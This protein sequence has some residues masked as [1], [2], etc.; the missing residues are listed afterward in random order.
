MNEAQQFGGITYEDSPDFRDI[1]DEDGN[2]LPREQGEF[3]TENG[4]TYVEDVET[5]RREIIP[6]Y[7][8]PQEVGPRVPQE[9]IDVVH[10]HALTAYALRQKG[11]HEQR[12][13]SK[14][15]TPMAREI[16]MLAVRGIDVSGAFQDYDGKRGIIE[17]D[18]RERKID[19]VMDTQGL[20]YY[21]AERKVD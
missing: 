8:V 3:T 2:V 4:M 17:D 11:A 13:K 1:V 7:G 12:L 15:Y 16:A 6:L 14:A 18:E 5:P 19:H 9:V 21:D 20:S 10:T